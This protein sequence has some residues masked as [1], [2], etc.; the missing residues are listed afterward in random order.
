MKLTE[1]MNQMD[2]I[3]IYRTFH[4]NTKDFTPCFSASH[5]IF[6]KT[7]H[8]LYHKTSLNRYK[9][10]DVTPYILSDHC[11]FMLEFNNKSYNKKP[12]NSWELSNSLLN[13]H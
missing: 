8:I 5:R 4:K 1:V 3:D 7:D 12:T 13:E 11:G 6:S 10:S 2:L 9:M